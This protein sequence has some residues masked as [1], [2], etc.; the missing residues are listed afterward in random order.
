MVSVLLKDRNLLFLHVPKTGGGSISR[1]LRNEPDAVLYPVRGMTEAEPCIQQLQRQLSKPVKAHRT[2][3]FVRN[4]WDWAVSGYLHVTQ[5]MP[6]YESPPSF[7][8]FVLGEWRGATILQYPQKFNTPEAYV[9][10]HTQI[11]PLEHLTASSRSV[12]ISRLCRFEDLACETSDVFGV[13]EQ[14]PHVNE[15]ARWH[16]SDYFDDETQSVIAE[17]HAGLIDQFG[18]QFV[19]P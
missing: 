19:S 17:R 6:A 9:A 8:N 4:P 11:T 16:Y 14:L 3:A 15:S 7:R 10:Y 13:T 18:Y 2:V 12:T 1:L 5:S